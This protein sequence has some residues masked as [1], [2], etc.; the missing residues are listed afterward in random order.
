MCQRYSRCVDKRR[1]SEYL[2]LVARTTPR[3]EPDAEFKSTAVLPY[4]QGVSGS[5]RRCLEQQG[6]RTVVKSDTTLRS[7]LVRPKNTV[8]PAQQDGVVYRIPCECGKVYIGETGDPHRRGSNNRTGI[9]DSPVPRPPP[10]LNTP[11]RPATILS[12][13]RS[14]LLIE[15]LTGIH[16]GSRKLFT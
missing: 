3:R 8:N 5:P 10:F 4:V 2:Y 9:Y 14:S 12:G 7:H 16:V 1:R 13:M 6:I 15:I 11:T